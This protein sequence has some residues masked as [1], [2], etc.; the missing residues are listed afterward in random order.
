MEIVQ[1]LLLWIH[2]VA[3]VGG[4]AASVAMPAIGAQMPKATPEARAALGAV[5]RRVTMAGRGAVVVL[6]ITG[7][8]LFWLKWS[9]TA[10][11]MTWFGIKM[12]F[13]LLILVGMIVGGI[14]AKKAAQGD[15]AAQ[16]MMQRMG[17][18]SGGSLLIVVLAAVFAFS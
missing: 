16:T 8:L 7:P 3:L 4:G 12:L 18:L 15:A 11:S 10:P 9:F 1:N 13:V 5:A 6:L 2:L 17:M 14:N